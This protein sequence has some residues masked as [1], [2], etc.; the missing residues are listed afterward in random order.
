MQI[1]HWMSFSVICP[2]NKR[3]NSVC[4][5]FCMCKHVCYI[6]L[7][8]KK[9]ICTYCTCIFLDTCQEP[10]R[11]RIISCGGKKTVQTFNLCLKLTS[12]EIQWKATFQLAA[13]HFHISLTR[14]TLAILWWGKKFGMTQRIA[15]DTNICLQL[16]L[17]DN[18]NQNLFCHIYPFIQWS[19]KTFISLIS[20]MTALYWVAWDALNSVKCSRVYDAVRDSVIHRDECLTTTSSVQC[21]VLSCNVVSLS[22]MGGRLKRFF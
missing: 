9:Y 11:E 8:L 1:L 14:G 2:V 5:N 16:G 22:P 19:Q 10:F 13:F 6:E 21:P 18:T 3:V 17:F 20:N 12:A 7:T 15:F 4:T